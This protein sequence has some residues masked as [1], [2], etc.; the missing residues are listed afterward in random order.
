MLFLRSLRHEARVRSVPEEEARTGPIWPNAN[1]FHH[2]LPDTSD[3]RFVSSLV[4]EKP[5]L[6][7]PS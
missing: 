1:P 2:G 5:K 7:Q 3:S 4:M 6:T